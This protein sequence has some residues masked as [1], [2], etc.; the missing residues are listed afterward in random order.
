MIRSGDLVQRVVMRQTLE[1][2]YLQVRLVSGILTYGVRLTLRKPAVGPC[3]IMRDEMCHPWRSR[4]R[5]R[6][7]A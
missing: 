2:R 3:N 5:E 6:R 7:R 1:I 4:I